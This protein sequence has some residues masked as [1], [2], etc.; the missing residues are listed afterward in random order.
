M[1][2]LG[3]VTGI[4]PTISTLCLNMVTVCSWGAL[5]IIYFRKATTLINI[6]SLSGRVWMSLASFFPVQNSHG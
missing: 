2:L 6:S 5:S 1:L 4:A 3:W